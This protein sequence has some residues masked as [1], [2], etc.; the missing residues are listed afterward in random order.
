[1]SGWFV[2]GL[3]QKAVI[4]GSRAFVPKKELSLGCE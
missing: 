2:M 1:M 3:L 4:R